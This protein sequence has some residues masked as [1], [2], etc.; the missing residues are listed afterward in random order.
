MVCAPPRA[1]SS[2]LT[3]AA[4]PFAISIGTV[5]GDTFRTPE[6]SSTSSCP[7]MLSAPP[8]PV[9]MTTASRSGS[10]SGRPASAQASRAATSAICSHRSSRRACTR[11]STVVGSTRS[12]AAIRAGSPAAHSSS[13]APTPDSPASNPA[14][15]EATSPPRGVVAPRPV[16]TT[17]VFAA[18]IRSSPLSQRHIPPAC[19]AA[20][21]VRTTATLS[22]E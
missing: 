5:C 21:A 8:V 15:V 4:G 12:R 18:V 14:Q 17:W 7:S 10:T 19:I 9:P 1:P 11:S 16:T 13:I 20:G 2:M 6:A 22:G 3:Q